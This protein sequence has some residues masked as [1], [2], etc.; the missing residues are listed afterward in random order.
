MPKKQIG[1][2]TIGEIIKSL[3]KLNTGLLPAM[4]QKIIDLEERIERLE[5]KSKKSEKSK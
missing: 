2:D 5:R 1:G 3:D 4:V